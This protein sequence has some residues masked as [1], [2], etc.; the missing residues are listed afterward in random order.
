MKKLSKGTCELM[1]KLKDAVEKE[2]AS[3][4]VLIGKDKYLSAVVY[5]TPR[6]AL[7]LLCCGVDHIANSMG[8]PPMA[9]LTKMIEAMAKEDE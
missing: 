3:C 6:E 7:G 4:V 8:V 1:A 2:D 9:V 5:G